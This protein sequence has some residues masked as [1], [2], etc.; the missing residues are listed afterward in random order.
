MNP[1]AQTI[2]TMIEAVDPAD[3]GVM[4]EIDARIC[5]LKSG[6]EFVRMYAPSPNGKYAEVSRYTGIIAGQK[7]QQNLLN[8]Q[9]FTR[10]IDAQEALRRDGWRFSYVR[11]SV[12]EDAGLFYCTLLNWNSQAQIMSP[13]S[14]PTEPLARLHAWVQVWG[15]EG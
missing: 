4:D 11:E 13:I 1:A 10:S 9:K 15:M 6:L 14:L 8:S 12:R 7:S 3:A 5:C 2:L